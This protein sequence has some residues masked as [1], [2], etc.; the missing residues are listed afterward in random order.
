MI[1]I[2]G[3]PVINNLDLAARYA[4][5]LDR[6]ELLSWS[7]YDSA[8]LTA[9][10]ARQLQFFQLPVNAGASSFGGGPKTYD[11]TN[12]ESGGAL[13]AMQAFIISTVELDLQPAIGFGPGRMPAVFGTQSVATAINDVWKVLCTGWL[14]LTIGS[15]LYLQEGPLMQFGA[16][17]T[18]EVDAAVADVSSAGANLQSRFSFAKAIGTPYT[19]AP[20]NLL[21]APSQNF[22]VTLNWTT[23]QPI[24]TGMR[25][26]ARLTGQLIRATQ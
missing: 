3:N 11:D 9:A 24:T 2:N 8:Q 1:D 19:L 16:A 18:L 22:G 10:G 21:L 4:A 6:Y 25:I 15:K 7:M 20:N 12:L 26:F 5:N 23:V 13:N 17:A 14:E